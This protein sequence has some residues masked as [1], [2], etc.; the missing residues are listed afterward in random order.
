MTLQGV[1]LEQ[2]LPFEAF[3]VIKS[4]CKQLLV[5][6]GEQDPVPWIP[7]VLVLAC[8]WHRPVTGTFKNLSLGL[9]INMEKNLHLM[10]SSC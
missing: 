7:L 5:C 4:L 2:Q 8:H 10:L 6:L 1:H 9:A 3:L